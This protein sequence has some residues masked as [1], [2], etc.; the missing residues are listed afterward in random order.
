MANGQHQAPVAAPRRKVND[1]FGMLLAILSFVMIIAAMLLWDQSAGPVGG[2]VAFP[3][4][5]SEYNNAISDAAI[6]S[7]V[8]IGAFETSAGEADGALINKGSADGVRVGD[9]FTPGNSTQGVHVEFCVQ[10]VYPSYCKAVILMGRNDVNNEN[11]SLDVDDLNKNYKSV[12]R[13]WDDQTV[14]K[15]LMIAQD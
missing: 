10:E 7:F 6:L 11:Y 12:Q 13:V 1:K 5:K 14:R 3:I 2:S 8:N 15:N 4:K 9:V